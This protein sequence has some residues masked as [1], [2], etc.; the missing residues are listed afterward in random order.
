M[1]CKVSPQ[2]PFTGH[3]VPEQGNCEHVVC[4]LLSRTTVHV[5][6]VHNFFLIR[7]NRDRIFGA[8]RHCSGQD[9]L[10]VN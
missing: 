3:I 1:G 4:V 2:D 10:S 6:R 5:L 7:T 8:S 9:V